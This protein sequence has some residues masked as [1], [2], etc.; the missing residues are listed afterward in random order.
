MGTQQADLLFDVLSTQ[1][2][3]FREGLSEYALIELLKKVPYQFFD[4]DALRD[5]LVLFKTHFV[6][7]HVLYKLKHYWR[8]ENEVNSVFTPSILS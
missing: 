7:F 5:P 4:E 1:K 3:L 8:S 2:A 6:L